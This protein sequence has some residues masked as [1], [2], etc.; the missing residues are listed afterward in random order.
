[1]LEANPVI[2]GIMNPLLGTLGNAPLSGLTY[3][4][5]SALARPLPDGRGGRR[6]SHAFVPMSLRAIAIGKIK[7]I[8]NVG[9]AEDH[10]RH[11]LVSGHKAL[12]SSR[13][14]LSGLMDSAVRSKS[15]ESILAT[16]C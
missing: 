13:A 3:E 6:F 12:S 9:V 10:I 4:T 2:H 14:N 16:A 8:Q 1:L 5:E 15:M 7:E 11:P